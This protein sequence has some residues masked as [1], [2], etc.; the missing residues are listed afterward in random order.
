M[1]TTK[2]GVTLE[3]IDQLAEKFC[4]KVMEKMDKQDFTTEQVHEDIRIMHH[5]VKLKQEIASL[6]TSSDTV[7]YDNKFTSVLDD[8]EKTMFINGAEENRADVMEKM[9]EKIYE[10][11]VENKMTFKDYKRLIYKMDVL[12]VDI[13]RIHAAQLEKQKLAEI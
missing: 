1:E 4:G 12:K 9:G 7:N 5:L 6:E 2:T 3:K 11:C 8:E 13:A 10:L